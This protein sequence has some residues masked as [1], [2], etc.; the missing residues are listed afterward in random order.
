MRFLCID[1]S[2]GTSVAIVDFAPDYRLIAQEYSDDPRK[3]VEHLGKMVEKS[4][5]KAGYKSLAQAEIDYLVL[6]TGPGPFTGLRAGLIHGRVL[7]EVL[8]VPALGVSSLEGLALQAFTEMSE[9]AV[10]V[11]QDVLVATD[12]KR[13]EVYAGLYASAGEND[14]ECLESPQVG[15][16]ETFTAWA[17]RINTQAYGSGAVL[18]PKELFSDQSEAPQLQA[19]YLARIAYSRLSQL[20]DK[21]EL[22]EAL[23]NTEP[24]YL[25]RPDVSVPKAKN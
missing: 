21:P 19:S 22:K 20:E 15:K 6:G 18:Y 13:R 14:V 24:L 16:A 10:L 3:H 17:G 4:V 11:S 1:T 5:H 23:Y 9:K 25:R 2:A 8:G 12:A 7:A